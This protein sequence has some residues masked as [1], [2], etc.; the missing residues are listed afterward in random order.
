MPQTRARISRSWLA[1]CMRHTPSP[2]STEASGRHV[3]D[4]G[5]DDGGAARPGQLQQ[6][7][8]GVVGALAVELGVE[9]VGLG[10]RQLRED[11]ARTRGRCRSTRGCP[12]RLGTLN[13]PSASLPARSMGSPA[14]IQATRAAGD[15]HGVDAQRSVVLDGLGAAGSRA[16]RSRRR[17]RRWAPRRCA[18]PPRR[19]GS[20]A[21]PAPERS[22]N[23]SGVRTSM[24]A[25]PSA[26][27]AASSAT[28]ISGTSIVGEAT[29]R[30]ADREAGRR[31]PHRRPAGP[32]TALEREV[33]ARPPQ[34][35]D[36]AR[37]GPPRAASQGAAAATPRGSTG[38]GRP[39]P[40]PPPTTSGAAAAS[41]STSG[42]MAAGFGARRSHDSTTTTSVDGVAQRG[43][44]GRERARRRARRRRRP[45]GRAARARRRHRRSPPPR[46]PR[47]RGAPSAT[48]TA[49]ACAVDLEGGLVAAHAAARAAAQHRAAERARS[50]VQLRRGPR[51]V[52]L[53]EEVGAP[54]GLV[55]LAD[56]GGRALQP[57]QGPEE[58]AVARVLPPH[59][60]AAP[61]PV[62]AQR[63]EAAVV[64]HPVGGVAARSRRGRRRRGAP[65]PSSDRGAAATTSARAA[66]RSSP[67]RS[68]AAA[69]AS[70]TPR[71]SSAITVSG[72]PDGVRVTSDM[73][74]TYRPASHYPPA[75][76]VAATP[77]WF[78][79]NITIIASWC[80][81]SSRSSCCGS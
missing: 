38:G 25:A 7:Q 32:V 52:E 72:G 60:A 74:G 18:P 68:R 6:R 48:R 80:W 19:A 81:S 24:S 75:V 59:V 63:V 73:P 22:A 33:G 36:A 21:R 2:S 50:A 43:E 56:L 57:G 23:S 3:D 13:R 27:R 12:C 28:S 15:V 4:G 8:A 70:R 40:A 67:V 53:P 30:L 69:S 47:P 37:A 78:A 9:A 35:A 62:G 17:C 14:S 20:A 51:R 79:D 10:R 77:A 66:R 54:L 45:S 65:S 76:L 29:R 16:R 31:R 41:R 42:A 26:C 44:R 49:I 64:A 11:L 5:V 61:P 1:A 55:V 58:P 34:R 46:R 39:P 71:G